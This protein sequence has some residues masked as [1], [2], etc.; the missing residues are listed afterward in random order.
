[1]DVEALNSTEVVF[2]GQDKPTHVSVY[3]VGGTLADW[4]YAGPN[5]HWSMAVQSGCVKWDGN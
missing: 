1:M 3:P 5:S 2:A 4:Y